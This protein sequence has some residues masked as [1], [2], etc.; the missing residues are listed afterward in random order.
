M[1]DVRVPDQEEAGLQPQG[2]AESMIDNFM[3]LHSPDTG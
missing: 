2:G 3:G 1:M